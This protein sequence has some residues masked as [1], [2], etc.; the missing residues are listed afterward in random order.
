MC[1]D[2]LHTPINQYTK[3]FKNTETNT[4]SNIQGRNEVMAPGTRNKFDALLF[5]PGVFREQ[6]YCSEENTFGTLIVIR[7]PGNCTSRYTP[8]NFYLL[9]FIVLLWHGTPY[10]H[11]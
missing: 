5:E 9:S 4:L 6:I 11:M 8:A 2:T 3:L 10:Q 1:L 7:R